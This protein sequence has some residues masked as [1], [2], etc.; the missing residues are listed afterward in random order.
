VTE[1]F[2]PTD[3]AA[4]LLL[5]RAVDDALAGRVASNVDAATGAALRRLVEAHEGEP[6]P[7]LA[8]QIGAAVR[9]AEQRRWLPVQVAAAVLACL[10]LG[11]GLGDLFN[12]EWVARNL[13][14]AFDSHAY[15]EGGVV[16]LSLGAVVMAGAL[17][18]RW[19]DIAAL[20]GAPV[21]V[22]FAIN[23]FSEL[24]EFPAGGVL[25]LSQGAAALA[26]AVLWWRARRY[27]L[28]FG[29]KRRV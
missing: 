2:D 8:A 12:A 16:L 17:A 10:L 11:Q 20:A 21:G 19:I 22:A 25:H 9:R 15:F 3:V 24:A 14:V 27:V 7:A 29:A 18:R 13:G 26:L 4:A 1:R 5:D 28:A 6:P 23:G